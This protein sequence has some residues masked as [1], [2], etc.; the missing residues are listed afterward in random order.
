MG[1]PDLLRKKP[2]EEMAIAV[3]LV[4]VA[5][6][7]RAT[8]HNPKPVEKAKIDTPP[9]PE[10]S[11]KPEPPKEEPQPPTPAPPPPSPQ[12]AQAPQP[13]EPKP[14]PPAPEPK[15]APPPPPLPQVKPEPKPEP[16]KPEPKPEPPKPETKPAPPKPQDKPQEKKADPFDQ[17]LKNLAKTNPTPD[18][19]NAPPKSQKQVASAAAA[20]AMPNAPLGSQ[21]TTSEKDRIAAAVEACWYDDPGARGNDEMSATIRVWID[22][23]GTVQRTE[24]ADTARM[25]DPVWR[26]FAERAQRAPLN[27]Q[28]NKLPIPP[29]KYE[30]LKVFTFTFTPQ[31]IS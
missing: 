17:L 16:P 21:I 18:Q 8:Q 7:T 23:D 29:D 9:P 4:N 28:C 14:Q 13:P 12:V 1:L 30:Q 10:P 5:D 19:T 2:P 24:I 3:Q 31:G 25:G 20:S 22:R 6:F 27:P 11:P 15:P 26:A